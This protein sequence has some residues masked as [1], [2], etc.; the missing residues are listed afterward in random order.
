MS[1]NTNLFLDGLRESS[2]LKAEIVNADAL[3]VLKEM[4]DE[5][6][7]SIKDGGKLLICGNGGS[8]A[9][10]QHL[11]AEL[12]V[13]LR[14]DFNRNS[15]P[16]L[17]LCQDIS[18]ITACG[19]DFGYDQLFERTLR[20]L[21][22]KGDILLGITTSGNSQNINL[23]FEAAKSMGIKSFGFLGSSGGSAINFCDKHYLVPSSNTARIQEVHITIGHLLMEYIEDGLL[24]DNYISLS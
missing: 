18:T 14:P 17:S 23:A 21:G 2:R 3:D 13:R 20:G 24:E 11:A 16:A 12:L 4:G 19:N 5:I 10:A 15:I 9:D 7:E 22:R 8:A 1:N 6:I